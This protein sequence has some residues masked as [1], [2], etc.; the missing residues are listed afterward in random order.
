MIDI[1]KNTKAQTMLVSSLLA[2]SSIA[3]KIACYFKISNN[4][5]GLRLYTTKERIDIS[6]IYNEIYEI[7]LKQEKYQ[8]ILKL[9]SYH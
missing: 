1:V 3:A 8:K 9:T 5:S 4:V 7:L 6:K 2:P